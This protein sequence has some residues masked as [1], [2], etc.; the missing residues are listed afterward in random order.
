MDRRTY[1][2]EVERLLD[3]IG[4]RVR[5]LRLMKVR[6][7]LGPALQD[8]KRELRQARKELALLTASVHSSA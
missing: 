5:E 1:R 4:E 8:R 2:R 7:A 6:G 3:Q